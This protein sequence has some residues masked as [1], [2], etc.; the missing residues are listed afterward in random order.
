MQ[1]NHGLASPIIIFLYGPP[2]PGTP[3]DWAGGLVTLRHLAASFLTSESYSTSLGDATLSSYMRP[4]RKPVVDTTKRTAV[5]SCIAWRQCLSI[6]LHK[7]AVTTAYCWGAWSGVAWPLDAAL[8]DGSKFWSDRIQFESCLAEGARAVLQLFAYHF[9]SLVHSIRRG[10][11]A[12]LKACK[13][14]VKAPVVPHEA[15]AQVSSIGIGEV[16][17]CGARMVE[18]RQW[19]IDRCCRPPLFLSLSC[20][21]WL[22]TYLPVYLCIKLSIFLFFYLSIYLSVCLSIYLSIYLSIDPSID[23]S[24]YLSVYLSTYLP[25]YPIYLSVCLSIYLIHLSIFLSFYLSVCLSIYPSIY[26]SIFLSICLSIYL[27]IYLS[28]YLSI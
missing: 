2:G 10:R 13:K 1:F 26:L 12:L 15:V 8:G 5:D 11:Q 16:G 7:H 19:C 28:F 6:W 20:R 23:L 18:Q 27:S 9:K 22:A 3:L 25:A 24:I 21:F 17:C 14:L 4:I